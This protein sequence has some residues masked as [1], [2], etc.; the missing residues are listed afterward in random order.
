[1]AESAFPAGSKIVGFLG[2]L[3]PLA[4]PSAALSKAIIASRQ[5]AA[6]AN[7]S[8]RAGRTPME[9]KEASVTNVWGMTHSVMLALTDGSGTADW[10]VAA[11]STMASSSPQLNA[12]LKN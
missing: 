7:E 6:I 10:G 8:A 4:P 9:T 11:P 5:A 2:G 1:M 12:L 3:G